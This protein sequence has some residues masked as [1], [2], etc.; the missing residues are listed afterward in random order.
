MPRVEA[1]NRDVN[2]I[3]SVVQTELE[4][5]LLSEVVGDSL[6]TSSIVSIVV[7]IISSLSESDG[8]DNSVK[9]QSVLALELV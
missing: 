8:D 3:T 2:H 1:G 5:L 9:S 6:R 7:M 4:P